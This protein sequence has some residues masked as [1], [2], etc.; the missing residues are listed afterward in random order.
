MEFEPV[1][2]RRDE[3][4]SPES[5]VLMQVAGLAEQ[6]VVGAAGAASAAHTGEAADGGV[7]ASDVGMD[8]EPPLARYD[9]KISPELDLL[10]KVA[11][12]VDGISKDPQY[13]NKYAAGASYAERLQDIRKIV[14]TNEGA[15]FGGVLSTL[16]SSQSSLYPEEPNEY[17]EYEGYDDGG[18]ED[19]VEWDDS[20]SD[21]Y[22]SI[23][24]DASV[25]GGRHF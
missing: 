3:Y 4:I 15:N 1:L 11:G 23:I 17:E 6:P 2:A 18:Y 25:A 9:E 8:L 12:C 22:A 20:F 19:G 10:M 14:C 5:D 7:P 13:A 24:S 21:A 16:R